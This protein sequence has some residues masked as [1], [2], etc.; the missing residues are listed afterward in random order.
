MAGKRNL[1]QQ[2]VEIVL[3]GPESGAAA[4]TVLEHHLPGLIQRQ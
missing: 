3:Q 4:V 2:V 1:G